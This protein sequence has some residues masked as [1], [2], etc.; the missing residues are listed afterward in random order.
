MTELNKWWQNLRFCHILTNFLMRIFG[1]TNHWDNFSSSYNFKIKRNIAL[2]SHHAV[3]LGEIKW[4]TRIKDSCKLIKILFHICFELFLFLLLLF[5]NRW[6][7]MDGSFYTCWCSQW[8]FWNLR[9][10]WQSM[11]TFRFFWRYFLTRCRLGLYR[12]TWR[13][14]V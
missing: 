10:I 5:V 3:P 6:S 8:Y 14:S 7:I 2:V 11:I 12:C 4:H 13:F 1:K 9:N